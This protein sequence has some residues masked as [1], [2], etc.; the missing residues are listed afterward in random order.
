MVLKEKTDLNK[1]VILGELSSRYITKNG[2]I[3]INPEIKK[4]EDWN[5]E[6]LETIYVAAELDDQKDKFI[7]YARLRI[8]NRFSKYINEIRQ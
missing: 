3:D 4:L 7:E 2:F 1:I 8:Y 5:I 6:P